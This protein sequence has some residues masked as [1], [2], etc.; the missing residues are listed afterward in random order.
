MSVFL[1]LNRVDFY[2]GKKG[3]EFPVRL[4][5]YF[6]G[7]KVGFKTGISVKEKNWI[8]KLDGIQNECVFIDS[9]G[10]E[11][12]LIGGSSAQH[13]ENGNPIGMRGIYLDITE[14]KHLQRDAKTQ[15]AKLESIFNSTQNLIM[16]TLNDEDE[17]TSFNDNF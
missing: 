14:M 13:D 10:E 4:M 11:L 5:Y 8:D 15:S 2:K 16:F 7:K 12:S 6:K 9:K 3:S 17:I 1:T